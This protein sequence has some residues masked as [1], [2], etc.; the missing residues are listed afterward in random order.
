[1][2]PFHHSGRKIKPNHS[3]ALPRY[4]LS[5]AVTTRKEPHEEHNNW[6]HVRFVSAAVVSGRLARG[7]IYN[8]R[9]IE[10]D[11]SDELWKHIRQFTKVNYTTW[12]IGHNVLSQLIVTG[13]PDEFQCGNL[14]IDRPRSK[15]KRVDSNGKETDNGAL[16]VIE[17][18][19]TIIGCR[20]GE[21][22]GR[23]VI[24]D[25]LNWF[26]GG[27]PTDKESTRPTP[28]VACPSGDS[29]ERTGSNNSLA[30]FHIHSLFTNLIEWVSKNDMGLFRYTASSQAMGA[31]RHRFMKPAI[32]VHDNNA[33]QKQ[34]R[35]AYFGGRSDMF[36]R[37]LIRE[38]A[39]QLDCNALFPSVM[40]NG[41]FPFYLSRYESRATLLSLLPSIDWSAS[42]AE[43]EIV[44]DKPLYPLRTDLHVIYP[45]GRFSTVLCGQELYRAHKTRCIRK[46]GSWSEYKL[47][48]LFKDWVAELW[49]MRQRYKTEHNQ[50]YDTFTKFMMNSLYGKFAQLTPA[51]INVSSDYSMLPW[52]TEQ[53]WNCDTEKWDTLRSIGWQTQRLSERTERPTSF[54][55]IAAFVTAAARCRMDLFRN[56]AGR[57][58]VFYQGVD[59]L[60]VNQHGYNWLEMDGCL[61]QSELGKLRLE[62]SADFGAI[63]GI[64]DYEL[65]HKVVLSGRA[66]NAET[67]N[68]GEVMQHRHYIKEHLFRDGPINSIVDSLEEW[69][70]TSQYAKGDVQT[71]GWVEPFVLGGMPTSES[72]GAKAASTAP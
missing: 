29:N 22:Q 71:D 31:Y 63:R 15:R 58:N 52:T 45:V 27:I 8:R 1:M 56:I 70:R 35:K 59:S 26:P 47:G 68:L 3:N 11:N 38:T 10:F 60:I 28:I 30:A 41:F 7:K 44:T 64:S 61:D 43:V 51:W 14:S 5:I 39:Y 36:K 62:H 66:L 32:Y 4:I 9:C 40:S 67:T 33:V 72:D 49:K 19:P 17:S 13:L 65:G 16:A 2:S 46:C 23:L 25:I 69:K 53:R 54:Y 20:V 42:V 48:Q 12:L 24:V 57:R 50:L 34:E 6:H 21:T 18:P 55:A 37:G